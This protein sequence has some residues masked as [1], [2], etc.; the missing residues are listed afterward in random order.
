MSANGQCVIGTNS[1]PGC[2]VKNIANQSCSECYS[3]YYYS[4]TQNKCT[5][6]NALCKTSN[7][8]TGECSTCYPGYSLNN[9]NCAVFFRDVNCQ[10]YDTNNVCKQCSTRYYL[11][12]TISKCLSVS[13]LC[14]GFDAVSGKCTGCYE[15]YGL[16]NGQ[17][18]VGSTS[19]IGS[20]SS[21]INCKANFGNGLCS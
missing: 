1:D 21:D 19:S 3:G 15:G 9:G 16:S 10:S 4:T 20:S 14:K 18:V 13:P 11:D 17:C 6:L 8:V 7:L 5:Q 2:K 12:F